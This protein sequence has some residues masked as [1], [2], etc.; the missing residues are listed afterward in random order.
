MASRYS[1]GEELRNEKIRALI[2][3]SVVLFGMGLS[4][5]AQFLLQPL[6]AYLYGTGIEADAFFVAL[7]IPLLLLWAIHNSVKISFTPI[8]TEVL[9]RKG[10]ESLWRL[11][12]LLLT[13]ITFFFILFSC[14]MSVLSPYII[15]IIAPGLREQVSLI[16]TNI[17][18]IISF[19]FIFAGIIAICTTL[20]NIFLRFFIPSTTNLIRAIFV[21]IATIVFY[22]DL[23]IYIIPIAFVA[24]G[25]FQCL[26]LLPGLW[27]EDF[28]YKFI[29]VLK[30]A[31]IRIF[32][33][34][35]LLPFLSLL[36]MY[37]GALVDRFLAS[38][39]EVGSISALTYSHTIAM[40]IVLLISGGL[41]S[42]AF[43]AITKYAIDNR[44]YE[45]KEVIIFYLK[46]ASSGT[47]PLMVLLI[48]TSK[49][50]I[51]IL[52]ERGAFDTSA[53]E[54]TASLL[55]FYAIGIFFLSV[56]PVM[57]GF[58]YAFKD[59]VTPFKHLL[60]VFLINTI[61]A[62]VLMKAMG[63]RGLPLA[64][65]LAGI[66]SF[67]RISIVIKRRIGPLF[68]RPLIVF[69]LK[70]L[71]STIVMGVFVWLFTGWFSR[72]ASLDTIMGSIK[73]LISSLLIGIA[74]F[75]VSAYLLKIEG[76]NFIIHEVYKRLSR[77]NA[78]F[79]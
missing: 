58:F 61:L 41:S 31:G 23:G 64:L 38:F 43:P 73:L 65:S 3:N 9:S 8:F 74:V 47:L 12:G 52:Y 13:D 7:T 32:Q 16:A 11:A 26:A 68:D 36:L 15:S 37:G 21:I 66:F 40:G 75:C 30:G 77:W 67:A 56:V 39:L 25:L 70:T 48:L 59:T 6:I 33:S 20:Q 28:A 62:V 5:F 44:S 29:V 51:K 78:S 35:T 54:L 45:I 63:V 18:R 27:Q 72:H 24:A 1:E 50:L 4:S 57:L 17:F 19:S 69:W 22:K 49:P 46:I 42:V 60:L 53:T 14:V 79:M 2:N 10:K 34:Q 55:S 71:V 76:R